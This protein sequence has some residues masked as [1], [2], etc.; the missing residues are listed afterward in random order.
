M[1]TIGPSALYE[2]YYGHAGSVVYPAPMVY[3]T[4][5]NVVLVQHEPVAAGFAQKVHDLLV[6]RTLAMPGSN[7]FNSTGSIG[8]SAAGHVNDQPVWLTAV[9]SCC[10]ILGVVALGVD[11]AFG[12]W[13]LDSMRLRAGLH[14]QSEAAKKE[15]EDAQALARAKAYA[16]DINSAMIFR[17]SKHYRRFSTKGKKKGFFA[18]GGSQPELRSI[19][20]QDENSGEADGLP[21]VRQDRLGTSQPVAWGDRSGSDELP[22]NNANLVDAG[23]HS[24]AQSAT[25]DSACNDT[26]PTDPVP[27]APLAAVGT[28]PTATAP[29]GNNDD[30]EE[31]PRREKALYIAAGGV[32]LWTADLLV[33]LPAPFL[34][35]ELLARDVDTAL[36]GLTIS[37]QL[38]GALVGASAV[39]Y[40]LRTYQ[41][42][43]SV[44][45]LSHTLQLVALLMALCGQLSNGAAFLIAISLLRLAMG[46]VTSAMQ[47]VLQAII[48]RMLKEP[49]V[50]AAIGGMHAIRLVA[51]ATS[52]P[53]GVWLYSIGGWGLPFVAIALLFFFCQATTLLLSTLT[54]TVPQMSPQH[55][56]IQ[57]VLQLPAIWALSALNLV[58]FAPNSVLEPLWQPVLAAPPYSLSLAAISAVVIVPTAAFAIA[59]A[60]A[61]A[62]CHVITGNTIQLLGVL[63]IILGLLLI[64]PSQ[65]IGGLV[66]P[67]VV[68]SVLGMIVEGGGMG[69][70][71]VATP[72]LMLRILWTDAG[73]PKSEVVGAVQAAIVGIDALG[74]F[75]GPLV[76]GS[77][78]GVSAWTGGL[79]SALSPVAGGVVFAAS[80][81]PTLSSVLA[82]TVMLIYVPVGCLLVRYA[83]QPAMAPGRTKQESDLQVFEPTSSDG[84][85]YPYMADV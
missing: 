45:A 29:S 40:L 30:E 1:R 2:P 83:E 12:D 17:G 44:S 50:P 15:A 23:L 42:L 26:A 73:L 28:S 75:L 54:P 70:T 53:L 5:A 66:T 84:Y 33:G 47:A 46:A 60:T 14:A 63:S 39:P 74:G 82:A 6:D 67:G 49:N 13:L 58:A 41:P 69:L 31:R 22:S 80:G 35:G 64:G 48:M 68:Q 43:R 18:E 61:P 21:R 79:G 3:A 51:K 20:E 76:R 71:F 37:L 11:M 38:L 8:G 10:L 34:S 77:L 32:G 52:A 16:T 27:S 78:T 4:G 62:L 19:A 7:S 72:I 25:G 65:L 56:S 36:L 57:R 24:I 55:A 9:I 81:M 85:P 59:L